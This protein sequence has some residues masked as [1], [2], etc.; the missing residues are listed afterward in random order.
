MERSIDCLLG[1]AWI[2]AILPIL[3]AIKESSQ[4]CRL[5]VRILLRGCKGLSNPRSHIIKILM[6]KQL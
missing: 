4:R 1:L 2:A 5:M 3:I 6:M